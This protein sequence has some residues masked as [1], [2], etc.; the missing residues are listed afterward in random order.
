MT[1][2]NE[3]NS[4]L[5]SL[6][7]WIAYLLSLN[8]AWIVI[9]HSRVNS[10]ALFSW[11]GAALYIGELA[12]RLRISE[13][14]TVLEQVVWSV[15]FSVVVFS[16]LFLPTLFPSLRN[17]VYYPSGVF[18]LAGFPL[19]AVCFPGDLFYPTRIRSYSLLLLLET[20]AVLIPGSLYYFRKWPVPLGR[21]TALLIF[22]FGL[23]SWATGSWVSPLQEIR[24]YSPLSPSMWISMA[25]HWGLP[26]LGLFSSLAAGR[27][28]TG[29]LAD[30]PHLAT[31]Q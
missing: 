2:K 1:T 5:Q 22:H 11:T 7:L 15:A 26:L 24:M 20:V 14:A 12:R 4:R 10:H 16:L 30:A 18:A 28:L 25:F 21:I 27:Y 3:S 17:L 29:R 23:W 9:W 6:P 8:I 31:Q 13:P 19:L